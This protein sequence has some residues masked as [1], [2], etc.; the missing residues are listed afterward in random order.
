MRAGSYSGDWLNDTFSSNGSAYVDMAV[1]GP[2]A[3]FTLDID[4]FAFGIT[5]VD[6]TRNFVGSAIR[7]Q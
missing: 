7:L 4:G 5:Q 6:V 3:T 2:D 1:S